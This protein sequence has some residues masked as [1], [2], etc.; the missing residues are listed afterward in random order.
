MDLKSPNY[1][2]HRAFGLRYRSR[3][4]WL[5][6][7]VVTDGS[8]DWDIAIAL[9]PVPDR[10]SDPVVQ[11]ARFEVQPGQLLFKTR[12]IANFWV[13]EGKQISI[14]PKPEVEK[15]KLC[16]LLFGG[17]TGGLLI[18]RG[19]LALHG[20]SIETPGGAVIVCGNSGAGKS[21]LTA[22]MLER[23][24]RI[25]DDNIAALTPDR[26]QWLVQ[27]GLGFIRLTPETL[28]LLQIEPSGPSYPA[29]IRPKYLHFLSPSEFGDRPQP[30]RHIYVLDR[31]RERLVTPLEGKDKLD[32]LRQF[33]YMTQMVSGLGQIENYFQ[34]WLK[35]AKTISIS[36]IGHPPADSIQSWGDRIAQLL[37]QPNF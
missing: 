30:L 11:T 23:G 9:E 5:P 36:A 13:Q 14:A 31:T 17:V 24:F 27:P 21:T 18:Q 2:I 6:V 16:N 32:I 15:L 10:L 20:C 25:L 12:T 8:S 19:T 22:L 4:S 26:D 37:C 1:I 28:K 7:P 3:L 35:L 33:T 34:Q 29:P